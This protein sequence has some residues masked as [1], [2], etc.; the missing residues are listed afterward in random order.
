MHEVSLMQNLMNVVASAAE[1]Q[2]GGKVMTV[3]LR[4]GRMAG[5]NADS[6]RFAFD[7][8]SKGTVAEEGKL[9]IETV[10]LVIHCRGCSEDFNPEQFSL[11]CPSCGGKDMMIVTGREM[12]VDYILLEDEKSET[13]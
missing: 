3:H 11:T 7:I 2:G 6:L 5:V 4:I 12:E 8:L 1:E 13:G 9:E 10:P